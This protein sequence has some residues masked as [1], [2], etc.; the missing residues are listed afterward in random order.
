MKRLLLI[1]GFILGATV[2]PTFAQQHFLFKYKISE[3]LNDNGQL[4]EVVK[5]NKRT[6][7]TWIGF[8]DASSVL[9]KSTSFTDTLSI[10]TNKPKVNYL[11][12]AIGSKPIV[13]S[14]KLNE[15]KDTIT[16]NPWFAEEGNK[17]LRDTGNSLLDINDDNEYVL[18]IT[19]WSGDYP[20]ID[21]PYTFQQLTATNLP[22]R[23]NLKNGQ[24]QADFL[25][26]NLAYFWI[27]GTTRFFKSK[28]VEQ[29]NRYWG[30]GPYIGGSTVAEDE[31]KKS[32]FGLNYG[33]NA[34]GSIYNV[35]LILAL[36]AETAVS[37]KQNKFNPYVGLGLGLKLGDV[38]GP[39]D[40]K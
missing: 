3:K 7:K 16:I 34:I 14:I 36:G 5:E 18:A 8:I 25:N 23:Y 1:L 28:F 33:I 19:N 24:F 38:Y 13:G 31:S 30:L 27:Y 12:R 20:H 10:F 40:N 15:S 32:L 21:V 26:I 29:R 11:K 37:S 6:I 35:S 39:G 9:K 2:S 17:L 22:I 4:F